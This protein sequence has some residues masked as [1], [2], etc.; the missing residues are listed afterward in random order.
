[1]RE[2]F[3]GIDAVGGEEETPRGLEGTTTG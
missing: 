2:P 1:M 3:L